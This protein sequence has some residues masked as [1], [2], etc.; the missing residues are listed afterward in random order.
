MA[1]VLFR[2]Y[3]PADYYDALIAG[4][5]HNSEINPIA[6]KAMSHIGININKQK[7]KE[8]TE[9]MTRNVTKYFLSLE[10]KEKNKHKN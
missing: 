8:V 4:T 3:A 1:Q 9:D 7:P 2:K 6:I 10:N 5:K